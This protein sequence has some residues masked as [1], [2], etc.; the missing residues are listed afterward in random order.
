MENGMLQPCTA[1]EGDATCCNG[2][3]ERIEQKI[4]RAHVH[5]VM[6][7]GLGGYRTVSG[8]EVRLT[9]VP[10][11][12]QSDLPPFW[13][14]IHSLATGSTVDR[15]GCFEFNEDELEAAVEFVCKAKQCHPPQN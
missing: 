13:L 12:E 7:D 9:E 15:C 2:C 4:I 14:E 6:L 1:S 3:R 5:L 11:I 8:L 10:W